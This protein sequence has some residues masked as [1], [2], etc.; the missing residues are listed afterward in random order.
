MTRGIR[1]EEGVVLTL[2]METSKEVTDIDIILI[3][4]AICTHILYIHIY[5]YYNYHYVVL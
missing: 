2:S 5:V 4:M 3:F 1:G